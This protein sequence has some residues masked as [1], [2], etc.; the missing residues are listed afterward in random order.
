M[1]RLG[2]NN[3]REGYK[4]TEHPYKWG[5]NQTHFY[6]PISGK[7]TMGMDDDNI[8]IQCHKDHEEYATVQTQREETCYEM[9]HEFAKYPLINGTLSPKREGHKKE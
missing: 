7:D 6:R 2:K 8:A 4:Q 1:F 9:T 3:I 5:Q